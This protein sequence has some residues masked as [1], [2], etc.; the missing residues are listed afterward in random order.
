MHWEPVCVIV[1]TVEKSPMDSL[2]YDAGAA[3]GPSV[4]DAAGDASALRTCFRSL[5]KEYGLLFNRV[6]RILRRGMFR[7]AGWSGL[8][9]GAVL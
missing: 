4:F 1:T 5:K 3:R 2:Q 7:G 8:H 6:E 9:R